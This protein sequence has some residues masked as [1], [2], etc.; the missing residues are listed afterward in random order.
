MEKKTPLFIL[1]TFFGK[2]PNQTLQEFANEVRM[3][4]LDEKKELVE[5]AAVELGVEV[6]EEK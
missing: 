6:D 3:L 5:L 4:S 2:L 1:R